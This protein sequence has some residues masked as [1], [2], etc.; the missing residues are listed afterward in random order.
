MRIHLIAVGTKMEPWIG[1]GFERYNR[2]LPADTQI[3][4]TE[5]PVPK[6]SNNANVK[7]LI[8]LE[9]KK[10]LAAAPKSC[11]NIALDVK[12]EPWS[13]EQ[14]AKKFSRWMQQGDDVA[15]YIG[16]P[17]GLSA[18]C[19]KKAVSKWSLSPLTLPHSMVRVIVAEQIY[20]A[21]SMLNNHPYHRA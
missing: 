7:H 20:R 6:R 14:L 1:Q 2:R 4:L 9:G 21:W 15:L 16:G 8:E 19:L 11:L 5:I 13:T 3:K 10:M 12:G 18:D 17:D